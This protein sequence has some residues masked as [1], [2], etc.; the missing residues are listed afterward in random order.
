MAKGN[1]LIPITNDYYYMKHYQL[2]PVN[3]NKW[4]NH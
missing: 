3:S 1:V 2:P 4:P